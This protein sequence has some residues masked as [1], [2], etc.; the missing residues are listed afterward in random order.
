MKKNFTRASVLATMAALAVGG[1]QAKDV[2]LSE[3]GND[4]NSGLSA[5]APRKTMT[6]LTSIL[7]TGDVIHISGILK[8][9]D[10]Y[11][12]A[13]AANKLAKG[14]CGHFY[15]EGNQ[16]GFQLKIDDARW[17]NITFVGEDPET[18]GFDGNGAWR[19]FELGRETN[20]SIWVD[21]DKALENA[22]VSFKN[23][24]FQN[25]GA[26]K[27][28]GTFYIHDHI[29]AD[30]DNCVFENNGI[31]EST[32]DEAMEGNTPVYNPS[33]ATAERGGA[34]HFQFG[35]LRITNSRFIGNVARRGGAICQTGGYMKLEDCSF[36]MNGAEWFGER[37][38][39]RIDGGALCL[40]TLHS[41]TTVDINRC[42]FT[43]NAAW[44]NGG[45]IYAFVNVDGGDRIVDANI[46]NCYFGGNDSYWE[47][48][49]AVAMNNQDGGATGNK[50]LL[51]KFANC[52]F[53]GNTAGFYGPN[54]FWKGGTAG[55]LLSL[56]N[57]TMTQGTN[58]NNR[59]ETN[60]GHGANLTFDGN[61]AHQP[62]F[63]DVEIYN[64]IM[65]GNICGN[66]EYSDI[67]FLNEW[68]KSNPN[69]KVENCVIGRIPNDENSTIKSE[70]SR[71]NYH[72]STGEIA[73]PCLHEYAAEIGLNAMLYNGMTWGVAPVNPASEAGNMGDKAYYVKADKVSDKVIKND[74]T[75]WTIR[76]F[77]I[78]ASDMNGKPRGEKAV[79]G[80]N[81]ID[82]EELIDIAGDEKDITES[83]PIT[84]GIESVI[85]GHGGLELTVGNGVVTA[86]ETAL[87]KVYT[88]GGMKVAESRG[89]V[90]LNGFAGG[91]YVVM[92]RD[93]S[94]Y[95]VVKVAR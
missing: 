35:E 7:E 86:T 20:L 39:R 52:T 19:F 54:M 63:I 15:K 32:M 36:E 67:S 75:P 14:H 61:E 72:E 65:E 78:S 31:P 50:H 51:M 91:V 40:W 43:N 11:N 8:M 25:G 24:R 3:T 88:V 18:D 66:N 17:A 48:G 4:D 9:E 80:A 2:Y 74:G 45:A 28:G 37:P 42:S 41:S 1:L 71:F 69:I 94:K 56:T 85:T 57:C 90:D 16:N 81:E 77:D 49:G 58:N 55:S 62:N 5:D 34:I 23:L 76:G 68:C 13:L 12:L 47:H 92:A 59:G 64:T 44:N 22:T 82:P 83:Y 73:S 10:E 38:V 26:P 87:I 93:G 84:S 95:A 60:A 46:T 21:P 6:N 70:T 30:F 79:V 33:D 89:S 53:V 29:V 27:E